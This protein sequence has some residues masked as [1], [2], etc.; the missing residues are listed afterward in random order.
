MSRRSVE[1]SGP[2]FQDGP[3]FVVED[4]KSAE[5]YAHMRA[6]GIET[7]QL[8]EHVSVLLNM[9]VCVSEFE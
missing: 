5:S 9:R 4:R 3:L 7:A 8:R 6:K 1:T 2:D